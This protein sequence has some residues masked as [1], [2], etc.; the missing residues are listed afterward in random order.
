MLR[1]LVAYPFDISDPFDFPESEFLTVD[2]TPT[3]I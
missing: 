3:Q 1:F 2:A